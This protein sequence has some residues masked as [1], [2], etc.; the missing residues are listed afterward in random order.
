MVSIKNFSFED[1]YRYFCSKNCLKNLLS[2]YN[3]KFPILWTYIN[4]KFEILITQNGFY[5]LNNELLLPSFEDEIIIKG[6]DKN[7][8]KVLLINSEQINKKNYPI[9]LVDTY[10]L[11]YRSEY[12]KYHA[13][14][15]VILSEVCDDKVAIIDYYDKYNFYDYISIEEFKKAR[16]SF[17]PTS[18]N[19]FS[20]FPIKNEWFILDRKKLSEKKLLQ[21]ISD[22]LSRLRSKNKGKFNNSL[23]DDDAINYIIKLVANSKNSINI[24]NDLHNSIVIY[25]NMCNLCLLYLEKLMIYDSKIDVEFEKNIIENMYDLLNAINLL[26]IRLSMKY[27]ENLVNEL[28]SCLEKL[29]NLMK[30]LKGGLLYE[31]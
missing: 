5:S 21:I 9:V 16:S 11:P 12:K 13:A 8:D 17:N 19:P 22:N 29:D 15:S 26:S 25:K 28:C 30:Q 24:F 4:L 14:H 31:T 10:Y 2:F 27:N 6:Q 1:E 3:Y 18:N 20:G 7:F 23:V